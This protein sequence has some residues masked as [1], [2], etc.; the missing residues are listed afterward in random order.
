LKTHRAI[1]WLDATSHN[2][3]YA[4]METIAKQLWPERELENSDAAVTL[5]KDTLSNW[6]DAWLMVFD[7]L[8]KPSLKIHFDY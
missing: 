8:D 5:V 1:F 7:N 4:A 6:S 3:L 2:A